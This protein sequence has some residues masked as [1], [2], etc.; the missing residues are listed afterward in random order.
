MNRFRIAATSIGLLLTA[1]VALAQVDPYQVWE[2]ARVI[3]RVTTVGG[4]S[5]PKDLVTKLANGI[6]E[7]LRGKQPGGTYLNAHYQREEKAVQQDGFGVKVRKT[8]EMPAPIQFSGSMAYKVAI[9]VPSRRYLVARNRGVHVETLSVD[10]TTE[11]GLRKTDEFPLALDLGPGERTQVDLKEIGWNPVARV[12]AWVDPKQGGS[13]SIEIA[14]S[15]PKLVDDVKSPYFESIQ[16]AHQLEGATQKL[17]ALE[18]RRLCDA[19]TA[20]IE[21]RTPGVTQTRDDLS[22][23]AGE[24]VMVTPS[25][26]GGETTAASATLSQLQKIEDLL[27]GSES[28]RREGMDL[29][30]QLIRSMRP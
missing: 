19:L 20:S 13:G 8:D 9:V 4:K 11:S 16:I 17:D 29:L 18:I 2:D 27:T 6:V 26:A 28:E 1:S 15:E 21:R 12:V 30:H 25:S 14:F 3:R 10:Y 23:A 7:Q 22:V 5:T 24:P